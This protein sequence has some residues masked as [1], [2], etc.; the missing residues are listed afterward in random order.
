MAHVLGLGGVFL[1]CQNLEATRHFYGEILEIPLESWGAQFFFRNDDRPKGE[2][3]SMLSFFKKDSDYLAP[4]TQPFM[5]N[6]RVQD[7]NGLLARL[8]KNGISLVG[9]AT[10]S[11]EFG[12]FAW[13]L[14]PE[15]NKIELWEP[16]K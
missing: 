6:L 8:E 3:Y 11:E 13:I 1:K 16:S 7:F 5:I 4:S 10:I 14:D 15:G 9:E 2:G 12:N